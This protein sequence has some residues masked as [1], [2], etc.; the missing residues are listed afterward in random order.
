MIAKIQLILC[1][2][3]KRLMIYNKTISRSK[4]SG[5]NLHVDFTLSRPTMLTFSAFSIHQSGRFRNNIPIY[6]IPRCSLKKLKAGIIKVLN[7]FAFKHLQLS[8]SYILWKYKNRL[9][10]KINNSKPT[11][12]AKQLFAL[13]I[14]S[15]SVTAVRLWCLQRA[16]RNNFLTQIGCIYKNPSGIKKGTFAV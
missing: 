10:K 11:S 8:V 15:F 7:V 9:R 1:I 16:G 12:V 2:P 5:S 14:R 6:L 4:W 13:R 3:H